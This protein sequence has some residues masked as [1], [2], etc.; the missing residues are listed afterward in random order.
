MS[1][2][3]VRPATRAKVA[4]SV[5]K[6]NLR[7]KK[8]DRV[9]VEAWTH[10][11]PWA[12]SFAREARR[13]G[14]HPIVP[15]EDEAA[16]WDAVEKDQ[17][18]VVGEVSD[19]EWAALGKTDVYIHFWGPGDRLRLSSLPAKQRGSL[20]QFNE[21]WYKNAS[22]AGLRGARM[23][24]GRVYPS[25]ARAYGSTRRSGPTNSSAER[26]STPMRSHGPPRRSR[27]PSP[28]VSACGSGTTRART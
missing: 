16:Y 1:T 3:E 11:L 13:L 17:N 26:W 4:R 8:G 10:T 19:H 6:N 20:F 25:L 24:L 22:K 7:V 18:G 28:G 9:I 21:Q 27:R 5:F 14:A 15:Y 23:E 12:V 2:S